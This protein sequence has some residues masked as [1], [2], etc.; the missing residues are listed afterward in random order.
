MAQNGANQLGWLEILGFRE[1]RDREWSLVRAAQLRELSRSSLLPTVAILLGGLFVAWQFWTSVA[2]LMMASWL[3]L[4]VA[5]SISIAST[6]RRNLTRQGGASRADLTRSVSHCVIFGLFWA[7][8][9]LFF[10]P[11][12]NPEQLLMIA[13]FS[14]AVMGA[15]TLALSAIPQAGI[16]LIGII[17]AALGVMLARIGLPILASMTLSYAICLSYALLVTGRATLVRLRDD[18]TL[19][20]HREVVDLLLRQDDRAN[21]D[22]L[23]QID[24]RKCI[25]AP[26]ARFAAATGLKAKQLDGLPFLQLLAG[27]DWKNNEVSDEIRKFH[28]KLRQGE[29][30]S[31]FLLPVALDGRQRWWKIS[32]TP[33]LSRDRHVM[34][35]RGV[36]ADVTDRQAA[37][38]RTQK[39]ALYDTLTG[40]PNRAHS[41][42][43][44]GERVAKCAE[45]G[46]ICG[47]LMIDLDRFK[48]INDTLGHPIGDQLLVQVAKRLSG[49]LQP[50]DKCG[51]LGGD[52]FA[53]IVSNTSYGQP[54]D[55]RA[56]QIIKALSQPFHVA[57]HILYIGASIGSA[58][59]PRDGRSAPTLL[60]NADLALYKSKEAGRGVHMPFEPVLL[61]K[62]EERRAIEMALRHALERGEF[63]LVYQPVITLSN[64]EIAGFEALLRWSN[65]D[66]GD[67]APDHF[68]PIAEETRLI[69]SIGEWVFRTACRDAAQWP[70][71]YRVSINISAGQLKNRHLSS[72]VISA[73]SNSGLDPKRLEIE[74]T[75]EILNRDNEQALQTFK[76]LGALGV[77]VALDDFG[78]GNST[79]SFVGQARL[80]SIKIDQSFIR[81]AE[82][83]SKASIAVIKAVIAMAESLGISTIAEGVENSQQFQLAERLGCK[84]VQGFFLD[85]PMTSEAVGKLVGGD[86]N[87]AVA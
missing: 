85:K 62:A 73:L 58:V 66:L 41:N 8:P 68:I 16:A 15:A 12:G 10:A 83:G 77:T 39:M 57:D 86:R 43:L 7:I 31:E 69:D 13:A 33:R 22:W 81:T 38:R 64:R 11:H 25:V 24:A 1:P 55:E 23:W 20:E 80:N 52:E 56:R 82:E 48:A 14:F 51:R 60:R 4:F 71:N 79:L 28:Q 42:D 5:N 72:A 53:M 75:E 27:A 29:T 87:R 74:T 34:G 37:E 84:Q 45:A 35:Y 49:L 3:G 9:P 18:L 21:S 6:R 70:E 59:C 30:F 40:I 2:P 46:N 47:F 44:L 54:I 36:I 63:H 26:S 78:S 19:D 50:G 76:Q 61:K 17:G 65:P 32:G 67:V